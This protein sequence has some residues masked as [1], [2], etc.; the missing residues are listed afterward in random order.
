MKPEK[1]LILPPGK[2]IIDSVIK[3]EMA[4]LWA[5]LITQSEKLDIPWKVLSIISPSSNEGVTT[6]CVA[7]ARFLVYSHNKSVCIIEANLRKPVFGKL[8]PRLQKGPGFREL[9][10]GKASIEETVRMFDPKGLFILPAGEPH[11][12]TN[13]PQGDNL[14]NVINDIKAMHDVILIDCPPIGLAAESHYLVKESN[15]VVLVA[16]ARKTRLEHITQA[17]K[18]IRYLG[19]PLGGIVLND[20]VYALPGALRALF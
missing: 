6:I 3:D 7:L 11:Y 14:K 16:R 20:V 1:L 10:L 8:L 15:F 13:I 9:L 4:Q 19:K 5:R 18:T 2:S 17:L 12:D